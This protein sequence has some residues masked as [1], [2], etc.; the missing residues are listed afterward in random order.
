MTL[1]RK[2]HTK[3]DRKNTSQSTIQRN[4][5]KKT[6]QVRKMMRVEWDYNV[7]NKHTL[8]VYA[9][10]RWNSKWKVNTI[11]DNNGHGFL[12]LLL[13]M[14]LCVSYYGSSFASFFVKIDLIISIHLIQWFILL[15][16]S[17]TN[18][19]HNNDSLIFTVFG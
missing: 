19:I 17:N 11:V 12:F 2:T 18:W 3:L 10:S 8:Y 1:T 4:E 9:E 5:R 7:K 13:L 16:I 15:F 6:I 14:L